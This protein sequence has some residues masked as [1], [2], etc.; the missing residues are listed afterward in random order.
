MDRRQTPS[1]F[2]LDKGAVRSDSTVATFGRYE[3]TGWEPDDVLPM[4]PV[5]T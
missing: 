3:G 2:S 4:S 5:H 1:E